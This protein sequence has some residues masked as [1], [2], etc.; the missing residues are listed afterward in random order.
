MWTLF[1]PGRALPFQPESDRLLEEFLEL[2]STEITVAQDFGEQPR[3]DSLAGVRR[4]NGGSTVGVPKKMMATLTREPRTQL[5]S[6][7]RPIPCRSGWEARSCSN[8]N[9]LHPDEIEGFVWFALDLK[10]KLDGFTDTLH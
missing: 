7:R 9:P 4:N 2:L 3:A 5:S 8:S 6:I 1:R 10:A